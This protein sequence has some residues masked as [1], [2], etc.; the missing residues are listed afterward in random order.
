MMEGVAAISVY[1]A[2]SSQNVRYIYIL[3]VS[4]S[5]ITVIIL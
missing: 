3:Y 1:W 5:K 2:T 4:Q